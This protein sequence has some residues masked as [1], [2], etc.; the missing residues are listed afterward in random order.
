VSILT[1]KDNLALQAGDGWA[2]DRL[3]RWEGDDEEH[4]GVTLW[5]SRWVDTQAA[6][7][8]DY[9]MVRTL[10]SRFPDRPPIA[11]EDGQRVI[12][13]PTH[14]VRL[15]RNEKEVRLQISARRFDALPSGGL[16]DAP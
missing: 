3:Y 10:E 16:T 1:G 4:A 7:D 9:A 15:S 2:G 11:L 6:K 13:T 5:V 8:F 14:V 12:Q